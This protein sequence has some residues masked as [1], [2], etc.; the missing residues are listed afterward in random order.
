MS[1][2][3]SDY[4]SRSILGD[5]RVAVVTESFLPQVNGVT[6]SVLRV[7]EHLGAHGHEV[8]VYAPGSQGRDE[9][10][11]YGSAMV[12]RGPSFGLPRY[13]DFRVG[14]PGPGLGRLLKEWRPDIVHLA[15]PATVGAHGAFLA[16]RLRIPSVAVYQTD[17]AGFAS[18]Y[19]LRGADRILWQWLRR[20][21]A[22]VGRTLAPSRHAVDELERR[23]VQ[24]VARWARGVDLERFRPDRRDDEL[25][26]R[27]AP[28]GELIV[29]YVGRLAPEKQ[30]ALLAGIERE[31]GIRL[32][33]VGDGPQRAALQRKMPGAEFL[34]FQGGTRLAEVF[35]SLD[36]F[37]HTG[38]HE[39]FCQAAQEALAS[40]LPVVAPAAGGLLD[41]VDE[42]RNGLLFTPD[43][44]ACLHDAVRSLRDAPE[45]RAELAAG[46]RPSVIGR[47]WSVIGDELLDHY[48]Q[49][50]TAQRPRRTDN[51][52]SKGTAAE[53]YRTHH[54]PGKGTA[55]R[56]AA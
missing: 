45:R 27:L 20:I 56:M 5:V 2:T 29:G 8:I 14:L 4:P 12:V 24:R 37:V 52:E 53:T 33:M 23:G 49:I 47:S 31:H 46:A 34:G 16:Q 44:P 25:R 35:A 7:C 9:P 42:G 10:D 55:A 15:S 40:G 51:G 21:H 48:E 30:V 39:T 13:R 28:N 1:T 43:N 19:G 41:L 32:V 11:T 54:G 36:V 50:T 17:L 18:R 38:S 22:A 3:T 26:S 6:N